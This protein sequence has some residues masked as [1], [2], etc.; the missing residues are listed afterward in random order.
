VRV[1]IN[2]I[3]LILAVGFGCAQAQWL[4]YPNPGI[5]RTRDGKA[6]LSARPPRTF[7]GKPDLSGVWEVEPPP[8]GE[9]ER[10][11][12]NIYDETSVPSDDA[13]TFSKY[14]FNIFADLKP[15]DIPMKPEAAERYRKSTQ[16]G[17]PVNP[18]THCLPAGIPRAGLLSIPFKMIQ[19]PGVIVMI[20]EADNTHRQI[21]TDGRPLPADPE[22]AWLGYSTG[23]WEAGTLVV[24]TAGFND[25]TTLDSFG[26]PHSESLRMTE[27]FRRLDFGH[28]EIGMTFED[29]V[30]YTRPF[31]IQ[32]NVRLLPDT[33]VLEAFCNENE[34]DVRHLGAR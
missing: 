4:N 29:P 34:K 22:P 26:H 21:Y 25:K 33:D 13:R 6:N 20:Y 24:E 10:L 17:R 23:K 14:F 11:V 1:L 5:R 31:S 3:A 2:A 8:P 18:E 12:P 7:D 15:Q 19:A 28:M 16:A 32:Y 30:N 27:R 9:I